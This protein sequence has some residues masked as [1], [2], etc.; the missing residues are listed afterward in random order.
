[1]TALSVGN[2]GNLCISWIDL[3]F[4]FQEVE[5]CLCRTQST[6]VLKHLSPLALPGASGVG[7]RSLSLPLELVLCSTRGQNSGWNK[8]R[9]SLLLHRCIPGRKRPLQVE[10]HFVLLHAVTVS[11]P[12]ITNMTEF[13]LAFS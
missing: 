1:M 6:L 4:F 13:P 3:D 11:N 5:T 12:E 9:F 8:G 7:G 10:L 2:V